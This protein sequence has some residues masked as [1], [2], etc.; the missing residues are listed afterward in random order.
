M[1]S[2]VAII[3]AFARVYE[4]IVII[5]VL[6]TWIIRDPYHP[7]RQGVDS[8]VRPLLEPIRRIMPPTGMFDFSPIV[9]LLLIRVVTIVLVSLF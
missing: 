3:V 9:L 5:S 7:V 1:T 2:I 4:W 6:L 8:L